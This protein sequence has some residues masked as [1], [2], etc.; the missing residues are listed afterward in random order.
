M[1][2]TKI[3]IET[4]YFAVDAVWQISVRIG[5]Q[6]WLNDSERTHNA[7]NKKTKSK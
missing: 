4:I 7:R 6:A 3:D 5:K 2:E 1:I